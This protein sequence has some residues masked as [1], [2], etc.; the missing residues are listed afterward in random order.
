MGYSELVKDNKVL[1]EN[2]KN[3]Y[4]EIINKE[5]LRIN[6]MV[7]DL[8]E[9]SILESGQITLNEEPFNMIELVSDVIQKY[10]LR[11]NAKHIKM[12]HEF[13]EDLKMVHGDIK[14]IERVF[15]NLL[16]NAVKYVYEGGFI[17]ITLSKHSEAKAKVKV[18][19]IGDPISKEDQKNIFDR[20]FKDKSKND[21]SG[22]GLA[23]SKKICELHGNE[24][25]V[26]VNDNI[27]S[28]YFTVDLYKN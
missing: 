7:N 4:I 14:Y 20:Y 27:N 23:I 12:L 6:S 18:C 11:M 10:S 13:D 15:Q 21:N 28:F 25:N 19:N 8:M 26:E 16:D 5:A 17:K 2:E 1:P 22:L 3:T 9:L 24:I